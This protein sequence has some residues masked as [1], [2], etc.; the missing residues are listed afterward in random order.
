MNKF[1]GLR[2]AG[3]MMLACSVAV[4]AL[5]QDLPATAFAARETAGRM[6]ALHRAGDVTYSTEEQLA[7]D[8]KKAPCKNEDRLPAVLELFKKSGANQ[9][10]ITVSEWGRTRNAVMTLKGSEQGKLVIGAHYDKI[11]GGCGAIDNW[12]GVVLLA[13]LY[14]T[15]KP[16]TLRRTMIFV[17]FGDEEIGLLGSK[18][19][20]MTIPKQERKSYCA[21][22]NLDSFGLATPQ[23]LDNASTPK[24]RDFIR[25]VAEKCKVPFTWAALERADSDSSSFKAIGVPA[26]T[27][28]GMSKQ[29]LRI[30]HTS[31]DKAETVIPQSV[32]LGYILAVNLVA[33]LD[34]SDCEAFR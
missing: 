17:A 9:D 21:M 1:R 31:S 18:A 13:H 12:T 15:F 33:Q 6:P 19:M 27:I 24:L 14:K 29:A 8:A 4:P 23:V 3:S 26:V 7:A 11:G 10:D 2:V 20:A 22:V 32:Y 34:G 25:T 5:F 30:I 28:H 16:L